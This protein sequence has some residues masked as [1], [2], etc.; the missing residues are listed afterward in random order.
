MFVRFLRSSEVS[1]SDAPCT[2]P[3]C[4]MAPSMAH[5]GC[6]CRQPF[7]SAPEA[8]VSEVIC[9]YHPEACDDESKLSLSAPSRVDAERVDYVFARHMR[10]GAPCHLSVHWA[11]EIGLAPLEI[12]HTLGRLPTGSFTRRIVIQLPSELPVVPR[13]KC[14]FTAPVVYAERRGKELSGWLHY[15]GRDHAKAT[16][17]HARVAVGAAAPPLGVS[18]AS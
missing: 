18:S 16:G 8:I 7:P 15:L 13:D 14:R 4:T 12:R 1:P 11:A 2:M 9:N 3:P 10:R 5:R 6:E 17:T